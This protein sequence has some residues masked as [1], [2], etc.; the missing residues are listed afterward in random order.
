MLRIGPLPS[1]MVTRIGPTKPF[2][3]YVR[4]WREHRGLTQ[5]Q[6]ADRLATSKGQISRWESGKRD[7]TSKVLSALAYA[8]NI[9]VAD[10]YRD[11]R[12]PSVDAL[13]RSATPAQRD[14]VFAVIETLLKTGS[15]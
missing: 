15:R 4:E 8:L 6:L 1:G 11:P 3:H 2:R 5:E 13:L 9:E 12:A 7:M 14:Q 10:L